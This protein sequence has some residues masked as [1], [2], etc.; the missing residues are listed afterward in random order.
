MIC[1]LRDKIIQLSLNNISDVKILYD[2]L[3][4]NESLGRITSENV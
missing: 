3:V 1:Y 2:K 4:S